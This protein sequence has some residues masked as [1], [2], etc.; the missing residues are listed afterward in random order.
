MQQDQL[1]GNTWMGFVPGNWPNSAMAQR[2]LWAATAVSHAAQDDSWEVRAFAE[3]AASC[4]GQWPPRSYACSY[5]AREFRTA[6]ALGGHMNVHRRERAYANQLGMIRSSA[7]A[8][9][10]GNLVTAPGSAA[11][12]CTPALG[13]CWLYPVAA[14][15]QGSPALQ[16]TSSDANVAYHQIAPLFPP[17]A[18]AFISA[19]PLIPLSTPLP[20]S[21]MP[22]SSLYS[23]RLESPP[24]SKASSMSSSAL[25]QGDG[26]SV[27]NS[28]GISDTQNEI[29]DL[30][31]KI[32]GAFQPYQSSVL[33]NEN[34]GD[35][36]ERCSDDLGEFEDNKGE[37]EGNAHLDLELRLGR[38][39]M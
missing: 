6:Q 33:K 24:L 25:S 30:S 19:Q 31:R 7:N 26:S 35:V 36:L 27:T 28:S 11:P 20:M 23:S 1:C 18:G 15:A 14:S 21:T 5:C 29:V 22:P 3:D 4:S 38:A 8:L 9:P 16:Q 17:P 13:L 32:F 39:G 34:Q 12:N 37:S 2:P 10:R